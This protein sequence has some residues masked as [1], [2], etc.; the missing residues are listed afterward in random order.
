[1]GELKPMA[2]Q[3]TALSYLSIFDSFALFMEQGTGKTLV[4]L[5]HVLELIK[6]KDLSSVLIVSTLSGI[7]AWE[8]DIEKFRPDEQKMLNSV[9]TVINY[10]KVWRT[11][12]TTG[13]PYDKTWEMIVVDESHSIKN[14]TSRRSKFLL[15]LSLKATYR[16]ILTGTP[17]GN[18]KLEN[19]WSQY[20][21]LDPINARGHIHSRIFD[22]S[23]YDFLNQYAHLDRYHNPFKYTNVEDFQSKLD[24]YCY[25]VYKV[26]CVDLPEKLPDEIIKIPMSAIQK[27]YYKEMEEFNVIESLN[28]M[29]ENPLA[30]QSKLRQIASG[31]V[32][33][34]ELGDWKS[35]YDMKSNKI[36][37]LTELVE[38]LGDKKIVIFAQFGHSIAQIQDAM[39]KMKLKTVTLDGK[40]RDKSIWRKFQDDESIRVIVVHYQSGNAGIDLYSSDTIIYFEPTIESIVLEQ[41]R[42][43]IHRTGQKSKCSYYHLITTGTVE[44]S[45]WRALSN[46]EDFSLSIFTE[47]MSKYDKSWGH[48]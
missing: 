14:R 45:I 17:I 44:V 19:I 28:I 8:R 23:Y 34:N 10:D 7:G 5:W 6:R 38:S 42:D 26:D 18:G 2:H 29:A 1:M 25:R 48:R 47:S 35:S 31:F 41:S 24:E 39:K 16:Y 4:I 13:N 20:A 3:E 40:Q 36:S 37:V 12:K 43:R 15:K 32:N 27:K 21:F 22:G 33:D 30:Q 11:S 9:I 46:F